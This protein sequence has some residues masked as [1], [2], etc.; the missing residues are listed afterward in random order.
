MRGLD[1]AREKAFF[2]LFARYFD[3]E[4]DT[5]RPYAA[6]HYSLDRMLPLARVAGNP[7]RR[8]GIEPDR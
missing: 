1:P 8:L 4:R 7:E 3:L 2:D 5:A 6:T